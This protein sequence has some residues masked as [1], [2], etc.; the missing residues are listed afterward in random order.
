MARTFSEIEVDADF[1]DN[2][3][4][5]QEFLASLKA[6]VDAS[7]VYFEAARRAFWNHLIHHE[8]MPL[9]EGILPVLDDEGKRLHSYFCDKFEELK[10]LED[11]YSFQER[12]FNDF[13]GDAEA[14]FEISHKR[15]RTA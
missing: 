7:T 8:M 2:Y 6:D 3:N 12:R 15:Q 13:M 1:E 4:R 11:E 10:D 9:D 5:W 14:H